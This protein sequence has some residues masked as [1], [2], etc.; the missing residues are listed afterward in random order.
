MSHRGRRTGP[1][2]STD[3]MVSRFCASS[4][5]DLDALGKARE[6]NRRHQTGKGEGQQSL[7]FPM[8]KMKGPV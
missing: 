3:E 1:V 4:D 6:D 5:F 7:R 2:S 8:C